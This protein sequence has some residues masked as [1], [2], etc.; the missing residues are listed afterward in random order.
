MES[1]FTSALGLTEPWHVKALNFVPEDKTLTIE[2]DFKKG[3]LFPYKEEAN[4]KVHDTKTKE[5]QHLNFFEHKT[6]LKARV[7]RV[8]TEDGKVK[9]VEVPWARPQ[10]GFTLLMEAYLLT[11]CRVLPVS[12]VEKLTKISDNRIWYLIRSHVQE[13][14]EQQDW[15]NLKRLGI[16]ET[17]T[18]KGHNYGTAFVEVIGEEYERSHGASTISRLL[19]FT[20]GKDKETVIKFCEELDK[21]GVPREQIQEVAMD[22]SR[23]FQAGVK[24]ELPD[25][26]VSFDRYHV[27]L[28]AGKA[29]DEVRKEVAREEGGLPK[30]AHW[31]LRGNAERLKKSTQELRKQLIKDYD[32]IGRAMAIR[33]FL[34]DTWHYRDRKDAEDHLNSVISWAS[35]SQ[36]TPFKKLAKSLRNNFEGIMGYYQNYTTS[37]AIEALNGKL[38]LAKRQA[39]GYRNFMNFQAIAYLI[40]GDL[41]LSRPN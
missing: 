28:L 40:A 5:W 21:R 10:S 13:L 4:L 41:P 6:L 19:F 34:K 1:L 37:A 29:C 24:Q 20:E 12:Q 36:L 38:Q 14:W 30:G 23:A 22:M 25:A 32:K 11:L 9:F 17:S 39:R 8:K 27:M 16:D 3:S 31:A 18:K 7:P 26:E 2:I 15:S 33:D 35:R